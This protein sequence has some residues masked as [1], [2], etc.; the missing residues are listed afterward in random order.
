ML[1]DVAGSVREA[2]SDAFVILGGPTTGHG[3]GGRGPGLAAELDLTR[4]GRDAVEDD[5]ERSP[6]FLRD[7]DFLLHERVLV[8]AA[9]GHHVAAR[10]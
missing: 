10:R 4:G 7:V 8:A 1:K 2:G 5:L 9:H 3:P 6:F